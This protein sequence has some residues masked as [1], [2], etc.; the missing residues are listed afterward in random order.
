MRAAPASEGTHSAGVHEE[1]SGW[2]LTARSREAGCL[3]TLANPR[4]PLPYSREVRERTGRYALSLGGFR[5]VESDLSPDRGDGDN[6]HRATELT[7]FQQ[8]IGRSRTRK[9]SYPHFNVGHAAA[10]P[11]CHGPRER[12]WPRTRKKCPG[13][14]QAG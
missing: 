12:R 2:P 11:Q 1:V 5:G 8:L 6:I 10:S 7:C 9:S 14:A 3:D 13:S 4:R